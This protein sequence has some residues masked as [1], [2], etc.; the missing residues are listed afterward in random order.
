MD[1]SEVRR[2]MSAA[3]SR[4]ETFYFED[5]EEA[6]ETL[7]NRFA[8]K[9]AHLF[10]ASSSAEGEENKLEHTAAYRE[11][12]QLFETKLE[13]II[14]EEGL[15]VLTFFNQMKKD[16]SED[17][18]VKVFA[19]ILIAITDYRSFVSMMAGYCDQHS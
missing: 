8:G 7:F 15:D 1:E 3:M 19:Q 16:A 13:A 6:G 14:S 9:H 12:V 11:F 2:R 10:H 18:D 17:E 4:I 5:G